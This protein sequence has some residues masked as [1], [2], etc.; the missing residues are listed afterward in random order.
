MAPSLSITCLRASRTRWRARARSLDALS[1][2]CPSGEMDWTS[3]VSR[4]LG[5]GSTRS[6]AVR[7][8]LCEV[9]RRLRSAAT[10]RIAAS[11]TVS[12]AQAGPSSALPG[13]A[14]NSS[15][16][17][18]SGTGSARI[19]SSVISSAAS[20]AT[21]ARASRMEAAS[22]SGRRAAMRA[23]PSG[24]AACAATRVRAWGNS[25]VSKTWLIR[26]APRVRSDSRACRL[27][28]L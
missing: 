20:S 2:T 21:W 3:L 25:S 17:V 14:S 24:P 11:A 26:P 1:S 19:A 4:S 23:A 27:R 10:T 7:C 9:L 13:T 18:M 12:S 5:G 6:K 8:A 15:D 22:V 28:V 16:F